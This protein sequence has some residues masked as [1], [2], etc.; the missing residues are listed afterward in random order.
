MAGTFSQTYGPQFAGGIF[1]VT[2][3]LVGQSLID[4]IRKQFSRRKTQ[5]GDFYLDLTHHVLDTNLPLIKRDDK[6]LI[7]VMF[8]ASV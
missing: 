8:E 1:Q 6:Q 4:S 3:Q 5:R 2:S 7:E